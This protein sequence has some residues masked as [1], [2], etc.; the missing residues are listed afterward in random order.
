MP[1]RALDRH[2][3][4]WLAPAAAR[5]AQPDGACAAADPDSDPN[6]GRLLA[7]WVAS[8]H[9]LIVAR[10]HGELGPAQIR[11]GL[12]L[13]PALGKR[14]LAF[15]VG[16]A[17][18][19]RSMPPPALSAANFD[20]LPA[21]WQALL[22]TLLGMPAIMSTAPRIYGSAALQMTTGLACLGA[23]SDLDL[24]LT[25][26]DWA[27]AL[28]ACCALTALDAPQRRPRLDGEIRNGAGE[29]VAWRE[30]AA[31]ARQLLVKTHAAVRLVGRA[32]YADSF[33]AS[34]GAGA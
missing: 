28:A 2:D 21:D 9:P 6:T 20:A 33:L 18:I 13:P 31:D 7:D 4:V 12:A 11:L 15:R 3:L 1:E 27:T 34:A 16:R 17:D 26:P 22:A 8:G 30:L 14:R 25:P 24:L 32:A 5:T 19:V 10:Q 29:A 23:E